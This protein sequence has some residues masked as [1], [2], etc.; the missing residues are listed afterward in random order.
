MKIICYIYSYNI[1]NEKYNIYLIQKFERYNIYIKRLGY[2]DLY[3]ICNINKNDIKG[4]K[5]QFIDSNIENW[6]FYVLNETE[7]DWK[8][9]I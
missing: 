2:N 8:K 5:K 3:Y 6:L 4:D 7:E 9:F 1:D